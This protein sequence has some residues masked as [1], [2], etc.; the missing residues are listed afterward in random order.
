MADPKHPNYI[1]PQIINPPYQN[2]NLPYYQPESNPP[3][4]NAPY[5]Q[6]NYPPSNYNP[7]PG[8][9]YPPNYNQAPQVYPPNPPM[10]SAG[11]A[12]TT[13][14][15]SI[16]I[17][18][19]NNN[20][21]HH[22]SYTSFEL[23][24]ISYSRFIKYMAI[25]EIIVGILYAIAF[26]LLIFFIAFCCLGYFGARNFNRCMAIGYL[27]YL[28][29][30]ILIKLILMILFPFVY[31]IIIFI[32]LMGYEIAQV[33]INVIFV[34]MLMQVGSIRCLEISSSLRFNR[35]GLCWY[36]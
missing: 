24:M 20:S 5:S 11:P 14:A 3:V 28:C 13:Q 36:F 15:M 9:Q 10:F 22:I 34:K 30:M 29:A 25:F 35:E 1:T 7:G 27:T 6:S 4:Y 26:S 17:N 16:V 31:V 12:T 21:N 2:P 19:T 8:Y 33:I 18:N 32:I 23:R